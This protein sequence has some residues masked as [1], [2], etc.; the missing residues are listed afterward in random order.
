MNELLLGTIMLRVDGKKIGL[1]LKKARAEMGLSQEEVG[2]K[3]GVTW[4]MIS[5]YEN[6]RSGAL[7]YLD[8]FSKLYK[9]PISY[10]VGQDDKENEFNVDILV[11]KL[12]EKGVTY[13]KSLKNVVTK[14]DELTGKG[15]EQD[16]KTSEVFHGVSSALTDKYP[17]VFALRINKKI[18]LKEGTGLKKDDIGFFSTNVEAKKDDIVIGYD[19]ISYKVMLHD[20]DDK[21]SLDTPLAVLVQLERNF[22]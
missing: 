21:D 9:K 7:K 12:K 8:K 22:R 18:E 3:I 15:I 19:G 6:G 17:E 13:N 16:L 2:Q 4:E 10:F 20:P 14:L 5:R 11:K 1:Q